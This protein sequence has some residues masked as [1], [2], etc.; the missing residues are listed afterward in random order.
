MA[1]AERL[2]VLGLVQLAASVVLLASAW[3]VTKQAINVGASPI[4]FAVGRAGCSALVAFMVLG[5][6][7]RLRLPGRRD[8]PALLGVGLLQLAAFFAF[9]HLA[10]AWVPA[11]RT[12][13]LSNVTTIFIVPL[14]MLVLHEPIPPRRWV[15]AGLGVVGVVVLMGPWAIDWSRPEVLIGHVFLLAAAAAF[16]GAIIIVRRFPPALSMLQLLPWCFGLATCVLM[17]L[18]AVHGG[19]VGVWPA[20]AV[21]AMAYIGGFAGPVG[22]W[23]VMEAAAS[24]PAMVASVGLLMTP[25]AGL[26]LATW[27]LGEPLGL[28]L[29]AG[30]ALILGGVGFAAWPRRSGRRAR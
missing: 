5:T 28:D 24:L 17:P 19:G 18:A 16:S 20:P 9:A 6:M 23:C 2:P 8:L 22:T 1:E 4:W 26:L 25:A 21:G 11:G 29:L 3:P 27:W 12:A 7:R 15:A 10:V 13:V 14:S 30:T